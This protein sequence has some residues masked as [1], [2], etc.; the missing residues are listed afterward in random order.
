MEKGNKKIFLDKQK[1]YTMVNLRQ[2]GLA[3]TS[4]SVI[5]GVNRSSIENQC[6]KYDIHPVGETFTIE[7]IV[8]E[9]LPQPKESSWM[10]IDGEKI[11]QG[12]TYKE[13][14]EESRKYAHR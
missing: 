5:Y 9:V 8:G 4:L 10:V 6:D 7:R 14:L 2:V 3:T 13:Y 12:K 1:L 11:N